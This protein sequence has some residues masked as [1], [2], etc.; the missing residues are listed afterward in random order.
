MMG[1]RGGGAGNDTLRMSF[2]GGIERAGVTSAGRGGA[3]CRV[4]I[5]DGTG[6]RGAF[7]M[8]CPVL[9]AGLDALARLIW[10]LP[11]P[12]ALTLALDLERLEDMDALFRW[13]D[14]A[15]LEC[16]VVPEGFRDEDRVDRG[17]FFLFK[18]FSLLESRGP[19]QALGNSSGTPFASPFYQRVVAAPQ[20]FFETGFPDWE[21]WLL[22]HFYKVR[23]IN[24][25]CASA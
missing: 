14:G 8:A 23:Q 4:G 11:F 16:R 2:W 9:R 20:R 22:S 12:L 3:T 24:N 19:S 6:T 1:T 10:A 15:F 5:G 18:S 21:L 13:L 25:L 7:A 17:A